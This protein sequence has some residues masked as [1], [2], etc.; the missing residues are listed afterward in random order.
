MS[1]NRKLN[2]GDLKKIVVGSVYVT[3][4]QERIISERGTSSNW[5]FDFRRVLLK[6]AVLD[7]LSEI[8]FDQMSKEVGR[9]QVGGIEVAAIPFVAG[10]V[11]KSVEKGQPVNGFFI[12]KSR[13][14]TGLTKMIEGVV[15]DETPIILVDDIIN[16]GKSFI[17]QVEVIEAL[18]K[19]VSAVYAILR[20]R[21][22]SYYTYFKD[23][24]IKVESLFSL[25][26]LSDAL[27]VKKYR[28]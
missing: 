6:P 13:K 26:D 12:R 7:S 3:R 25:D 9:F 17:R 11:M 19:K 16:T 27:P 24:E 20:F 21:D 8:F 10:V 15:E 23:K 28:R 2:L 18:G 5:I 1:E 22:E 4:E 14:K